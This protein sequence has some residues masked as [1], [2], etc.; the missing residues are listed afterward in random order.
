MKKKM[1][2]IRLEAIYSILHKVFNKM[3]TFEN[4]RNEERKKNQWCLSTISSLAVQSSDVSN[5]SCGFLQSNEKKNCVSSSSAAASASLAFLSGLDLD[6][7]RRTHQQIAVYWL[8]QDNQ[9]KVVVFT[10]E[11]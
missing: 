1:V 11:R 3:R 10:R 5:N 2:K 6:K 9:N 7:F 4:Y 8:R